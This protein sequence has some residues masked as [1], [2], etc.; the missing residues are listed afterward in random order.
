[1]LGEPND[2]PADSRQPPVRWRAR[3]LSVIAG[4]AWILGAVYLLDLFTSSQQLPPAV[5]VAGV[6]V[7]GLGKEAAVETLRE[8]LQPH[9]DDPAR[10]RAGDSDLTVDPERVGV[11]GDWEATV[12]EAA[13]RPSSP[14][15]WLTSLFT[16]RDVDPVVTG[17]DSALADEL[18]ALR[19]EVQRE[20]VEGDIEFDGTEPK[21]VLPVSGRELDVDAAVRTVFDDWVHGEVIALPVDEQ[22]TRTTAE[23]VR[24]ALTKVA[25]PAVAGAV[26]LVGDGHTVTLEPAEI[27]NLLSFEPDGEGGLAAD[28]AAEDLD[29]VV[30]TELAETEQES[31]NAT[32]SFDDDTP[33]VEPSVDGQRLDWADTADALLATLPTDGRDVEV[34]YRDEPAEVTTSEAGELGIEEVVG[35]FSTSGFAPDS[36]VNIRTVA[37]EVNGVIIPP[38]ESFSLN[39]FTG[40]RGTDE[41]YVSAGIIEQGQPSRAVGGGISQ[42][43]TTLY[44]AAYFAAMTDVEHT[45]HSYYISRYPV[46][47]EATVYQNPDGSSVIDLEFRNEH[48]TGVAI[49]TEWTPEEITVRIWGT[50]H[51]EVESVTGPKT[52]FTSPKVRTIPYGEEC[53]PSNGS[54][55]F[56]ATDTRII[57]DLDGN[58]VDREER[59]VVYNPQPTVRCAPPP[60]PSPTPTREPDD[61]SDGDSGDEDSSDGG[62]GDDGSGDGDDGSGNGDDG[63]GDGDGDSGDSSGGDGDGGGDADDGD[64]GA[65]AEGGGDGDGGA[66]SD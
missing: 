19:E 43:A 16:R 33:T 21:A 40:P 39:E 62:S 49:E 56:T 13:A 63:S 32:M 23:G 37:E 29:S 9:L 1:M 6:D 60:E 47:R 22:P 2:A 52:N 15:A 51:Y 20:H 41:G 44:N 12:D 18:A 38:G 5:S 54:R 65:G 66:G 4:A 55:G 3:L 31:R 57:R 42:F 30:G 46:A 25:R 10:V 27:A 34:A 50:E 14:V 8:R 48:P 24:T 26:D 36:G 28:V 59:T 7:G 58:E 61:G 11:T 64:G 17:D 35:E 53:S 45:E